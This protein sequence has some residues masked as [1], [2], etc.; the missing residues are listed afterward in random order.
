MTPPGMTPRPARLEPNVDAPSIRLSRFRLALLAAAM[1]VS[2]GLS[3]PAVACQ[4]DGAE[5]FGHG[6]FSGWNRLMATRHAP[7]SSPSAGNRDSG[8]SD[9]GN[10]TT[11]GAVSDNSDSD[12][13]DTTEPSFVT[14]PGPAVEI[15]ESGGSVYV[16]EIN[17]DGLSDLDVM[18]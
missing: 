15:R 2:V 6:G 9:D 4:Y 13:D 1:S 7:Q 8:D 3:L 5:G 14:L 18:R 10:D 16:E 17:N 11:G 12:S